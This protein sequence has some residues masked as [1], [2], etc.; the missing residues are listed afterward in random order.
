MEGDVILSERSTKRFRYQENGLQRTLLELLPL[1]V[2]FFAT[3]LGGVE[4]P[5]SN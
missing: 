3:Q 1:P 2:A 5:F 4:R